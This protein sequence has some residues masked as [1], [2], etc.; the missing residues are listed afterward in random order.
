MLE[1]GHTLAQR[2][3]SGF[4]KHTPDVSLFQILV[5]IKIPNCS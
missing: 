2:V 1:F 5:L 4:R 3:G